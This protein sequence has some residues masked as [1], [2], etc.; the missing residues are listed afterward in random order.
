VTGLDHIRSGHYR[1]NGGYF[2]LRPEIFNVLKEGEDLVEMPFQ[3]LI[4]SGKLMAFRHDGFW[5]CM[6]TFRERQVLEDLHSSGNA[7]WMVWR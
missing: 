4:E 6:D 2:V 3:R 7:P 1:I 5:A